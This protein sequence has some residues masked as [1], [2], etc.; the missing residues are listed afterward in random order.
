MENELIDKLNDLRARVD[1]ACRK[2]NRRDSVELLAISKH[3]SVDSMG[4]VLAADHFL[5]GEN[6]VQEA[7]TKWNVLQSR[8]PEKSQLSFHLTGPLQRNKAKLAVGFFSL[9]HTLDRM[10]LA[11]ALAKVARKRGIVQDV[12]VQVNISREATK[13]GVDYSDVSEFCERVL[14]IPELRVCG[15]MSI[16]KFGLSDEDKR[17]EFRRMKCLLDEVAPKMGASFSQLSM[18]MSEDFEL[19]IEEGATIVRV[20]SA[21][22][23]ER[24]K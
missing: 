20:G 9:I 10:E 6:Y 21:L 17:S 13:S 18:G 4:E 1:C 24:S 19:A 3:Q 15:L 12:L 8:F 7:W 22:F 14:E 23:G 11:L 16:G 5:F 2:S